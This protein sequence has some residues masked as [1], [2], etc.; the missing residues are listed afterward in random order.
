MEQEKF[1]IWMMEYLSDSLDEDGR[2]EF[3]TFLQ[4]N[5]ERQKQ[6][7]TLN[8]T[9]VGMDDLATPEPSQEMDDR[10]FD[11]LHTEIDKTEKTKGNSKSWISTIAELLWKPQMAYGILILCMGLMGGYLLS[12]N[13]VEGAIPTTVV[14]SPNET[15]EVRE[16]LVLTLLEQP[17]ANQRLQGINEVNKIGK[18]DETVITALLKTLN[19]DANVNVRLAAIESLTNYL[20]EPMVR[21]GLVQSI[22][23]QDSPIIQVTLAN[24]MVALQEKESI[25]PFKTLMRTKE[26][27]K[28]VKQKLET[29]INSII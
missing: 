18:I 22:V 24:L 11:M 26:L 16:Q 23:K 12:S 19:N 13:E 7:E 8:Q 17:S 2:K 6:F 20:E 27:D 10:F 3:E 29:S 28:S 5:A 4:D 9:W 14:N 15:E 25:E 1:E 21:E